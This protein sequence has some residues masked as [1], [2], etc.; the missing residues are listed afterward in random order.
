MRAELKS[1]CD[2]FVE[3]RD[4]IKS[5]FH[6][7][8]AYLYPMCAYLLATKQRRVDIDALKECHTL[9]K[10]ATS[11][12]SNFRGIAKMTIVTQLSLTSNRE[13]SIREMLK[14]YERL[15]DTVGRGSFMVV[16]ANIMMQLAS[17]EQYEA[18]MGK[19]KRLY[20]G[21]KQDHPILTS[22]EDMPFA[23]LLAMSE[24]EERVMLKDME[25]CYRIMKHEIFSQNGLQ[26]LSHILALYDVS[27]EIKCNKVIHIYNAL[28]GKGYPYGKTYELSTLGML[29]MLDIDEDTLINEIIEVDEYLKN[30]RGF[31][32][33]GIGAKQR[34]MYAG[35]LVS[36]FYLNEITTMQAAAVSGVIS[37]VIA[38][39]VAMMAAMAAASA[40]AASA[41]SN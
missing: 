9:L 21:M 39:E 30:V 32:P 17:P 41:S 36:S 40:A 2:L 34:L 31:G 10:D 38:N 1:R 5:A 24:R 20:D 11:V 26:S 22:K 28:K 33:F 29:A 16:V 8:S 7:E 13:E 3:N 15:K 25:A 6:W 4:E 12:F 37:I 19:T 23:A 35:M 14:L 18:I 27:P